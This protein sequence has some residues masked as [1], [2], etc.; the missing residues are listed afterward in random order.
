[1]QMTDISIDEEQSLEDIL[2]L[3]L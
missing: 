1:M 3:D 2:T